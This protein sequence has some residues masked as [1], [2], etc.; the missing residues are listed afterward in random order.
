MLV[1]EI[2]EEGD[3]AV[4]G[5]EEEDADDVPLLVRFE[6]V[7]RVHEDEEHADAQRKE[8]KSRAEEEAEVVEGDIAEYGL[9]VAD[10]LV[11]EGAVAFRHG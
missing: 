2:A 10:D 3:D 11:G 9:F 7:G 1:V 6:V 8:A 5:Y 4:D